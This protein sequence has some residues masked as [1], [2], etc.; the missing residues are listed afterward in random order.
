VAKRQVEVPGPV[1]LFGSGETSR[2]A[3]PLFRELAARKGKGGPFRVSVL[4]T[5]AGFEPNAARVAG[6]IADFLRRRLEEFRPRVEVVPALRRGEPSGTDDPSIPDGL[7][8]SDLLFMGPGSPTYA[9]RQLRGTPAWHALLAAHRLGAAAVFASAGMIAAGA[10]AIPVYEICK[11]GD[12]P[13]WR[14]GL[15]LFG[16]YGLS[17]AFVPHWNNR[18]GG[19]ELDTS[20]CY[21][22]QARFE[23]LTGMLPAG[24]TVVG[25]DEN[26]ALRIDLAA[27]RASVAGEGS[28]TVIR[29][30][31]TAVHASGGRFDLSSLGPFAMRAGRGSVSPGTWRAAFEAR[32]VDG[33]NARAVPPEIAAI[34]DARQSAR[35]GRDWKAADAL[36]ERLLALGWRVSDSPEGQRLEP[37]AIP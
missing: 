35:E 8:R 5:P 11:V 26:T 22:G 17:L 30:G 2:I 28:V 14:R 34:A 23:R 6:R 33:G 9:V 37:A 1:V 20:R 19:A 3:A 27:G 25:V 10:F 13:R 24:A 21:L 29:G 12:E 4:G 18:D 31:K 16:R 36:R 15:D 32:A 7:L